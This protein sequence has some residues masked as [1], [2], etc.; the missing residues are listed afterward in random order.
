MSIPW[1]LGLLSAALLVI[2]PAA[3]LVASSL[4][5]FGAPTSAY[6]DV[7]NALAPGLRRVSNMVAAVNFDIRGFDTL[8]EE[9]ML[10][11]AVTGA[12][13]LL[14]G[15]R[16]ERDSDKAGH[17]EG[18]PEIERSDLSV[19]LCRAGA[20]V[21]L[22]F[23]LYVVLHGTVTPGGGFQGGVI[24]ASGLL[25]VYLGEGYRS[26]RDVVH[27]PTL[28]ALEGAGALIF[29]LAATLPLLSGHE[30]LDNRLP[31]G[32]Y[33]DLWS[34]GVIFVTNFAVGLSVAGSFGLLLLEFMEETRSSADESLP[35]EED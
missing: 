27:A 15:S 11:C 18:R 34:G 35:D 30:A 19:L 28:A 31:L 16:G 20:T 3:W 8:G 21:L 7:V 29:V 12:V 10:L 32:T 2:S 4:P 1:R 5:P 17:I 26:W 25:L 24:A 23:G 14:R 22:V 33:K 13:M 9:C 6:G